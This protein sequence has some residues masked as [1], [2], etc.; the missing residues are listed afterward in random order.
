MQLQKKNIKVVSKKLVDSK[1]W[2]IHPED[3][4]CLHLENSRVIEYLF[5]E[6]SDNIFL[7]K[8]KWNEPQVWKD[9]WIQV[10]LEHTVF[11]QDINSSI[12]R[13]DRHSRK[14]LKYDT[15]ELFLEN[16]V[17]VKCSLLRDEP[18]RIQGWSMHATSTGGM[19]GNYL[20]TEQIQNKNYG[21]RM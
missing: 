10:L 20:N 7:K 5:K 1:T 12:K 9:G 14:H 16:S 4:R 6:M 8:K 2:L 13:K 15:H 11:S 19:H 17:T 3:Y 18:E 21:Y